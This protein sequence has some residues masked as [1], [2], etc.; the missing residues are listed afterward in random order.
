MT[1]PRRCYVCSDTGHIA[2]D[3][4]AIL[5]PLNAHSWTTPD[6]M[7]PEKDNPDDYRVEAIVDAKVTHGRVRYRVRWEGENALGDTWESARD[8]L[9]QPGAASTLERY[10]RMHPET[11]FDPAAHRRLIH[12]RAAL[13]AAMFAA[14]AGLLFAIEVLRGRRVP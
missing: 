3:C 7:I 8:I 10:I 13:L 5:K 11:P 1:N 2:R 12:A 9:A 4:C 14:F 6:T